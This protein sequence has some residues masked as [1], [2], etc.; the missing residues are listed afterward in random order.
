MP[1]WCENK[2]TVY[3]TESDISVIKESLIGQDEQG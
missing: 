1:N 2:L 3:G